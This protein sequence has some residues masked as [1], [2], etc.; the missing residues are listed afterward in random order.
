MN[1]TMKKSL[2]GLTL[3]T[4]S[5]NAAWAGDWVLG[6]SINTKFQAE[7]TRAENAGGNKGNVYNDTDI[8][9]YANYGEW[10]SLNTDIKV[11][12]QRNDNLDDYYP[13]SNTAFRSE[14]VT[15]RQLNATVRPAEGVAAW[16][17][18]IHPRFGSAWGLTPGQFYNFGSD[19]EQDE[20]IG[21]GMSV[22]LPEAFGEAELS[23]ETFFLDNS[24]LSNS[25]F[26]RP[27]MDDDSA[28]R[29]RRYQ[30]SSGGPSNTGKLDSYTIALSGKNIAGLDGLN[31]QIS[32]TNEAVRQIDERTERG[33]SVGLS[34][35]E[36]PLSHRLS[37]T[38]FLEYT[39]FSNFSGVAN[40]ERHYLIG[41]ANFIYGHW[42]VGLSEG[43]RRSNNGSIDPDN[44]WSNAVATNETHSLDHQENLTVSYEVIEHLQIGA[45][46]NHVRVND[47]SST[48]YGPSASYT[49]T[50]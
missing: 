12:R 47:R 26:S 25:L 44:S 41:G 29:T 14:G 30:L 22:A 13:T 35:N 49:L 40:L 17:G 1:P 6:G 8:T 3:L 37:V 23:A 5:T 24:F 21:G 20:R 46:I 4:A 28:N 36:I 45:G 18:K 2:L 27:S 31:Y 50:F 43:L 9:G 42:N 16:A 32:Y 39:H 19:Y 11:E 10:L 34:Y 33:F 48:T 15:L 7:V 38:P